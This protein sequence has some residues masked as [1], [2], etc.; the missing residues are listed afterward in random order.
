MQLWSFYYEKFRHSG[1]EHLGADI[2]PHS[3]CLGGYSHGYIDFGV[4][5]HEIPIRPERPRSKHHSLYGCCP[6]WVGTIGVTAGDRVSSKRRR[7]GGQT[8][9]VESSALVS[10]YRQQQVVS[11]EAWYYFIGQI[12]A[13]SKSITLAKDAQAFQGLTKDDYILA[14]LSSVYIDSLDS[15]SV[16]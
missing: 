16:N 14:E 2:M 15:H 13:Y 8:Y 9:V 5:D 10:D 12:R 6:Y 1:W 7:H 3:D 4:L 11:M